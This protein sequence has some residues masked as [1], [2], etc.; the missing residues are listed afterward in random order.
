MVVSGPIFM[1]SH[2]VPFCFIRW[3]FGGYGR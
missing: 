3:G 1:F 2:I